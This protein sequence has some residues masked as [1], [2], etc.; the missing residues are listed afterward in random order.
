MQESKEKSVT[1]LL[2]VVEKVRMQLR[3][4]QMKGV[5]RWLNDQHY[6]IAG[7]IDSN[8]EAHLQV[9]HQQDQ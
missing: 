6:N 9:H 4:R 2:N 7:S 8:H 1:I 3:M 5:F